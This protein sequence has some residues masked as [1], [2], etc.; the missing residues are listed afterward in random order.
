MDAITRSG[1][2]VPVRRRSFL[3][4]GITGTALVACRPWTRP[5]TGRE[6]PNEHQLATLAA[7]AETFVPGGDGAPSAHDVRAVQTIVDPA[8][9]VNP[10][11]SEVVSDLDDWCTV[12]HG[13]LFFE[14]TPEDRIVALEE[15]MGLR[16]RF[17]QSAYLPVYEGILA[18]T[19]LA[20]FGGL[21]NPLGT[22]Y[23][24]FPGPSKG[25]APASAAGAYASAM[26]MRIEQGAISSITVEGAGNISSVRASALVTSRD[27][28]Q[29]TLRVR[30]P[31]GKAH[32]LSITAD[33]GDAFVD[34]VQLPLTGSVAAGTWRL[35]IAKVKGGSGELQ[36]W[37][38]RLRTNLD[39]PGASAT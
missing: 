19:K 16:D 30:A 27:D 9:G 12:Q 14:L 10:Y 38:L 36:Y 26:P 28:L 29:A 4:G 6:K 7:I 2:Y 8:Y 3:T 32:E 37:S 13:G 22:N 33:D 15:R 11:I 21:A 39:E 18:L 35:E 23:V 31:D 25:Y 24:G 17:V 1:Q 5:D 20:F 34:D